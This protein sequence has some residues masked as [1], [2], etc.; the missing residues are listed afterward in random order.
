MPDRRQPY[1]WRSDVRARLAG[2]KLRPEDEAQIVEE[3]GHHLEQQFDE[4]AP[5]V[6]RKAARESLLAQLHEREFDEA[7]AGKR[8]REKPSGARVWTSSSILQDVRYGFRSLRRS[9]GTLVA[10]SAALA[11]GIGLTTMM[12]SVIYG[13][14]IKGLPYDDPSRI[15]VVK[16][17]DPTQPGVDALVPL[18]DV[19]KYRAQQ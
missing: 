19:A 10:G 3:V 5:R 16:F 14:L 18:A 6:G 17:I 11:L 15:A 7:I 8:R 9:P 2:A 13:L 4:L 12:F 1:D